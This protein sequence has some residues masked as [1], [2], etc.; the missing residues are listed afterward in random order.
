MGNVHDSQHSS[1][2]KFIILESLLHSLHVESLRRSLRG[3]F[4]SQRQNGQ[5]SEEVVTRKSVVDKEAAMVRPVESMT[6][7]RSYCR[8]KRRNWDVDVAKAMEV[9]QEL[10]VCWV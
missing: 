1:S 7:I 3:P 6:A 2:A 10:S 5:S 4:N 9:E 8:M